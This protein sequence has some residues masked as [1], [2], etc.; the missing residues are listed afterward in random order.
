MSSL[1]HQAQRWRFYHRQ[2]RRY[3]LLSHFR[4]LVR[5]PPRTHTSMRTRICHP[6]HTQARLQWQAPCTR[7]TNRRRT[8]PTILLLLPQLVQEELQ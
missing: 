1:L 3:L 2:H 8:L 4:M 6:L 7:R 5:D